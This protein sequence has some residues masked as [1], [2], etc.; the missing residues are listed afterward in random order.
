MRCDRYEQDLTAAGREIA[1]EVVRVLDARQGLLQVDDVDAVPLHED[2]ALHLRVPTACLVPEVNAGLQE[3][4]H[5]D[6]G[7][8]G[9]PFCT[10]ASVVPAGFAQDAWRR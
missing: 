4:F 6:N 1:H 5:G 10:S 8:V 3:L 9:L 2:E 7:H